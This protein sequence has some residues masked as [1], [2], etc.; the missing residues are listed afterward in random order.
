MARLYIDCIPSK[1]TELNE[2]QF[3]HKS[4][5]ILKKIGNEVAL[6]TQ[7]NKL[8]TY[9]IAQMGNAFKWELKDAGYEVDYINKLTQWFIVSIQSTAASIQ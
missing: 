9:K 5:H 2:K 8:N 3:S 4:I 7:Q 1:S 6:F